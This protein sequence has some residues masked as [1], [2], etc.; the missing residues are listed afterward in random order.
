MTTRKKIFSSDAPSIRVM[1][2]HAA[3]GLEFPIVLLPETD[4]T[5]PRR[6]RPFTLIEED[7]YFYARGTADDKAQAAIW[8]DDKQPFHM[9]AEGI[10]TFP[11]FPG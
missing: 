4:G 3:K 1:T 9:I 2:M 10:A 5:A 11:K 8:T 7:G 6:S